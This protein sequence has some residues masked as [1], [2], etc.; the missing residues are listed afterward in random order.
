MLSQALW[1]GSNFLICILLVRAL[2]GNYFLKYRVFFMYLS[3]VLVDSLASFCLY[4]FRPWAYETYYWNAQFLSVALGYG[5]IW[6]IYTQVFADYPGVARLAR[7]ALLAIFVFLVSKSLADTLSGRMENLAEVPA[8]LERDFRTVQGLLLF[9]LV[10]LLAYY[11]IPVGRNLKGMIVGYGLFIA[12]SIACLALRA[13]LGGIFQS[14]WQ[15]LQPAAYNG[16]LLIW[17]LSLWSY[18][19]SPHSE[20][21]T[22]IERDYQHL[23]TETAKALARVRAYILRPRQS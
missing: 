1:W 19:P 16:A 18:Q 5:V 10:S 9:I 2:H 14:W 20:I 6:E 22:G 8:V 12:V 4:V 7:S 3:W 21:E 17:C 11:A 15:Y 13:G 23:A